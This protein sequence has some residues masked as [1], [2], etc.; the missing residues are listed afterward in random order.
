MKKQSKKLRRNDLLDM[1]NTLSQK[2]S[3]L[4]S[5]KKNLEELIITNM[6]IQ[7]SK[8][9]LNN[10]HFQI[11]NKFEAQQ[12]LCENLK[13]ELS[14]NNQR[15]LEY[16]RKQATNAASIESL[17][18]I[19]NQLKFQLQTISYNLL[20]SQDSNK[21][22]VSQ[23]NQML[24]NKKEEIYSK[25]FLKSSIC[26]DQKDQLPKSYMLSNFE[27]KNFENIQEKSKILKNNESP[28]SIH[29]LDEHSS[30]INLLENKSFLAIKKE[31]QNIM[32]EAAGKPNIQSETLNIFGTKSFNNHNN[33]NEK[34]IQKDN[35]E[36]KL[37]NMLNE[38]EKVSF[39]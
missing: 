36:K 14:N 25:T 15:I 16:E 17:N 12:K 26:S 39:I 35:L 33:S 24:E 2:E 34:N 32:M 30:N 22:L 38:K 37:S 9:N 23:I 20:L 21:Q 28:K 19:N 31:K 8:E 11:Q 4:Q 5:N 1:Q 6:T 18:N 10:E 29:Y 7:N 13:N 27:P 3:I